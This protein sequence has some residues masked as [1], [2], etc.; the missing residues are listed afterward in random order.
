MFQFLFF[1]RTYSIFMKYSTVLSGSLRVEKAVKI[2]KI[3][4][5]SGQNAPEELEK[6]VT[7]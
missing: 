6:A 5:K 7:K 2:A 1:Y 4:M 3:K